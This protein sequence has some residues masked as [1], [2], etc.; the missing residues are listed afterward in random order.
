MAESNPEKRIHSF[1]PAATPQT[2]FQTRDLIFHS[3]SSDGFD[4][5]S[6]C[7]ECESHCRRKKRRLLYCY[8]RGRYGCY[9]DYRSV[10]PFSPHYRNNP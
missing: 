5:F 10:V 3:K 8:H 2:D 4:Q 9:C 7:H 1:N 6:F